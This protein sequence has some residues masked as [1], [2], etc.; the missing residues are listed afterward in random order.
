LE[1]GDRWNYQRVDLFTVI[2]ARRVPIDAVDI[3]TDVK[4]MAGPWIAA[5]NVLSLT[6]ET[7]KQHY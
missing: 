5:S 6:A 1:R 2:V 3:I 7:L 4:R